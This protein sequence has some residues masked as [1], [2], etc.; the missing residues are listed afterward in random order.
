MLHRMFQTR[1]SLLHLSYL[2]SESS[3]LFMYVDWPH[4]TIIVNRSILAALLHRNFDIQTEYLYGFSARISYYEKIFHPSRLEN[5]WRCNYV[6]VRLF[7][8]CLP[9][10]VYKVACYIHSSACYHTCLLHSLLPELLEVLVLNLSSNCLQRD[11][12]FSLVRALP[13]SLKSCRSS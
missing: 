11:T 7:G 5:N 6:N 8:V 10:L 9:N 2:S 13:R 1:Y 4:G 12:Q 3:P